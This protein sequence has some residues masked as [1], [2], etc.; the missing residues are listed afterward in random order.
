LTE[1][2]LPLLTLDLKDSDLL[3]DSRT[4]VVRGGESSAIA[5]GRLRNVRLTFAGALSASIA[6]LSFRSETGRKMEFGASRVEIAFEGPL[7]FVNAL[8]SI[9]PAD[10]FDDPPYVTVDGQGVVAGYTLAVPS[11]GVGIFSIQNIS[12]GAALSIP[13]TDRPAGVRFALSE[14]HKPFLL[15]VTLFGGGGFFAVGVS[16]NGLESVEASVEFGGNI[17]LNLGVA[18]GGVYVMAGVY[19]GM[20]GSSV[21]LTGYLRCG[22]HVSVLGLISVSLEFYLAFTYRDKVPGGSEIWGQASLTVSVKV[23]FF[24]TSVTL[25]VERRFAGSDGDPSFA[26]TVTPL[27]WVRYLKAYAA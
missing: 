26:D 6:E 27:D 5:R 15:T 1:A 25:S 17:S 3:L 18:S 20:T 12:V 23:A 13:W 9:L 10:G 24:S 8:Q 11:V 22:G 2:L 21:E 16:A 14:R 7:T 4:R 19:F